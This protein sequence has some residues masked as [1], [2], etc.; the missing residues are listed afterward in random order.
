MISLGNQETRRL[1]FD[2]RDILSQSWTADNRSIVFSSSRRANLTLWRVPALGG[3]IDRVP[4]ISENVLDPSFS[5]DGHRAVYSHAF[6]DTN[7]WELELADPRK[8][9][10]EAKRRIFSTQY[11]SSPQFSPDGRR[12]AFRSNRSGTWE[13]WVC[14]HEGK[15]AL[16]LTHFEGTL[17]GTPRWSP[18]GRFIA[19]DSR[20]EGQPEI[21]L[22]ASEGGEPQRLT[23]HPAEDVVPSW[24][25]DGKW[26]YFASLRTGAWQ[27]WKVSP[28]GGEPSR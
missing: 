21:Y 11:D 26:I 25:R 13:I 20:P 27:V 24:S 12:I 15:N 16:Q 3:R 8:A 6:L 18:D 2:N 10:G 14:D 17:A 23:S 4:A 1:T 7:V 28:R 22:I 9:A 19:F 5:E